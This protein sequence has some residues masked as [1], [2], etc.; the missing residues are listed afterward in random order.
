MRFDSVECGKR[1]KGLRENKNLTQMQLAE[2]INIS[3]EHM[4]SIETGRRVCSVDLVVEFAMFFEVSLDYLV[5]GRKPHL[6][7]IQS[8]LITAIEILE[9]VKNKL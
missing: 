6:D 2:Q 8:D 4:R 5:I 7:I 3:Y 9:R 1:I